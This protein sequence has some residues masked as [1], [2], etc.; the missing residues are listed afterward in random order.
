MSLCA[1]IYI[2]AMIGIVGKFYFAINLLEA[3]V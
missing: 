1:T 3:I 2:D